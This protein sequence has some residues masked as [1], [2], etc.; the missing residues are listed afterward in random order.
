MKIKITVSTNKVG[1]KFRRSSSSTM[2]LRKI[3]LTTR[4]L[5][6]LNICFTSVKFASRE[7]PK[8]PRKTKFSF[9]QFVS[10]RIPNM[11]FD[12]FCAFDE[13]HFFHS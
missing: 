8:S 1:S 7:I 11:P 6:R 10:E 2:T 9:Y 4:F 12:F 3:R 5:L 13:S